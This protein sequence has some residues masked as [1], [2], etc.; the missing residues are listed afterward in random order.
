MDQLHN[1]DNKYTE[2]NKANRQ[3]D[4]Q[5]DTVHSYRKDFKKKP[6]MYVLNLLGTQLSIQ[7][8]SRYFSTPVIECL[9]GDSQSK[10]KFVLEAF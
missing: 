6:I 3:I 5:I 10:V 7:A 8:L 1:S 9:G 4:R 2:I